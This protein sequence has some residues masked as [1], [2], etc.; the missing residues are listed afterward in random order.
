MAA[1]LVPMDGGAP[2]RIEKPITLVGRHQECDLPLPNF[3]K[4]SR[5]HCCLVQVGER[6]LVRDL[7]SMNGLRVN[8]R[9]VNEIE[10]R[11]GDELSIADAV[12][13]FQ[14]GQTKPVRS[15]RELLT[16]QTGSDHG[17]DE[18][19]TPRLRDVTDRENEFQQTRKK[20]D[21]QTGSKFVE[22]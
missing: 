16:S 3:V 7:G 19:I 1:L 22:V 5:R 17:D 6:Y 18:V 11:A 12:F 10:L 13:I 14:Y 8:G 20:N 9:R 15:R 2:F 21:S 4:V